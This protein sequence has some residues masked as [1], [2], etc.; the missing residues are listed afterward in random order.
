MGKIGLT[1]DLAKAAY[2]FIKPGGKVSINWG[3]AF[4]FQKA[5]KLLDKTEIKDLKSY[6]KL[7]DYF[8]EIFREGI[9][10]LSPEERVIDALK[11]V[12]TKSGKTKF[13][14]EALRA[15]IKRV[16]WGFMRN[17]DFTGRYT[18]SR[19]FE[20]A[21]FAERPDVNLKFKD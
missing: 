17:K 8:Q 9:Y 10:K 21:S 6:I 16:N 1:I 2:N 18:D 3:K 5:L 14:E 20:I 19:C 11:E 12:K 15:E 4:E 7:P 13:S